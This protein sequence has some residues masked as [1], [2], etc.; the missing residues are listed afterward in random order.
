MATT[1][2]NGFTNVA[3]EAFLGQVAPLSTPV[4][5]SSSF[6]RPSDTNA[7]AAGDWISNATSSGSAFSMTF[8][9]TNSFY[10]P[11]N[12]FLKIE[13][14]ALYC[15]STSVIS[16]MGNFRLWFYAT[17]QTF[18]DNAAVDI[19][20]NGQLSGG[21]GYVDIQGF[22]SFGSCLIT[23]PITVPMSLL[24]SNILYCGLQT[25][26]AWTPTSAM[27]FSLLGV[28]YFL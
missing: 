25:I 21:R 9:I 28:G 13:S 5:L 14:L 8:A 18:N 19:T 12:R 6:T 24:N 15:N 1:I 20:Y 16:G 3:R 10:S 26:N 11:T 27:Q 23:P 7:Y 2:V 4:R 17:S 22:T